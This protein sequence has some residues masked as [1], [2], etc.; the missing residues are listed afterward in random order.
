M[1]I[2]RKA[3]T[4][5]WTMAWM[6]ALTST[7]AIG[8]PMPLGSLLGSK[9]A[10]LDGQAPLPHTTLLEG[11]NLRVDEGLAMVTLDQGNRMVLGRQTRA[12][13][14]READAVIVSLTQGNLSLYHP[15]AGRP[16][17]IKAGDVT[18]SPSKGYRTL[19]QVAMVDGL[20]AVT[21]KDGA[22]QVE[23]NGAIQ[24]VSKGK[25]ITIATDTDRA[26]MPDSQ[27]QG[28]PH[29]KRVPPGLW[30]ALGVA[31]ATAGIAWAIVR[32]TSG[33]QPASP[34]TPGP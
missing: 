16:F 9:N 24:E 2:R 31:A 12:S 10:T 15:Q 13:F 3:A 11:D 1:M 4:F 19:G 30:I 29:L 33:G 5:V 14:L 21:A 17:R 25:T 18:V 32:S 22:L 8:S 6:L 7:V 26:P 34:V 20:L 27:G 23:K 28:K